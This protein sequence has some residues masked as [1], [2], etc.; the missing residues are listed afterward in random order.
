M[1]DALERATIRKVSLRVLPLLFVLY[2][3]AFLDRTNLG[4]ASLQL[5]RDVGLSAAAYGF[6]AGVFFIGYGLFE[7]PSNVIL[8]RV[9]A[10]RWIARIAITWGVIACAM[11]FIRG[12]TSF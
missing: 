7:V 9:G 8:A 1:T 11:M 2:I 6:G 4:L 5:N 12:T 3:A 10:Q